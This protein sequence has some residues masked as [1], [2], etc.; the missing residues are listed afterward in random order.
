MKQNRRTITLVLVMAM[1][2]S[3]LTGCSDAKTS[4]MKTDNGLQMMPEIAYE[5]EDGVAD[6]Y[7]TATSTEEYNQI[8]ENGFKKVSEEPLSTF[9][10]DVDTASYANI[11]RMIQS[12]ERINPDAVRLEE[13]INYF[14]YDYPAPTDDTPFSVTTELHDCPWNPETE[15]FL[16]G[17]Q[18]EEIEMTNRQPMNL[19]FLIDVS[20]SMYAA[21]KLPLVQKAF[22]ML[23]EN[24]TEDDRISIVTYAG[25]E[26]VVLEGTPGNDYITINDALNSLTA[27]GSTAGEAGIRKAYELAQ[28][29]FIEGGNNR[30]LLA[31]DGDLNVGLSSEEELTKL[32]E[33]QRET[34]VHLSVL[35]FGTGN[36]KDDRLEALADNGN[37]NYAYI[38]SLLEARKVLVQEMGGTLYTVAK[39]VKIQTEFD[40]AYVESYRLIGYENRA[41]ANEDFANDAVDAGEIGSGHSVTALYELVLTEEAQQA[42][43]QLMQIAMRYK[44]PDG[45]E[46]MLK[47]YP[48]TM[49]SLVPA[50]VLETPQVTNTSVRNP[51]PKNLAFAAAVTEFGMLLRSS[52]YAG[53]SCYEGI[54]ELLA[55]SDMENPYRQEF[56]ELVD[57][58]FADAERYIEPTQ[59]HVV[60]PV[61]EP[62]D[63]PVVELPT[64]P[65][66]TGVTEPAPE[67]TSEAF[68]GVADT[69]HMQVTVTEGGNSRLVED[70]E[71][72]VA[73]AVKGLSQNASLLNTQA[74]Q[75]DYNHAAMNG[76]MVH[77]RFFEGM[78][79]QVGMASASSLVH[80]VYFLMDESRDW[81]VVTTDAGTEVYYM[82]KEVAEAMAAY[83]QE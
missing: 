46:S 22:A 4:E 55:A 35:G 59:P 81:I 39:D 28:Q 14:S 17:L 48:I 20:G 18:A 10:V 80:E 64:E 13:M 79:M 24:M 76:L 83:R 60:E 71:E 44:A 15:L 62:T 9:S 50:H 54:Q 47:E 77:M 72:L 41:L 42:D 2:G 6:V 7:T 26:A 34:G 68:T 25:Q 29:Y 56:A 45:D 37:G 67:E 73:L 5:A 66:V 58:V 27:G 52:A 38:D 63:E 21:N 51:I 30:V 31:T 61:P 19:V 36:L 32:V 23:T 11:R 74:T 75:D 57:T 1:L 12:G 43:A 40:P 8:L 49:G 70:A 33:E 3:C 78:Y 65:L 53:T 16:V 82:P 69:G